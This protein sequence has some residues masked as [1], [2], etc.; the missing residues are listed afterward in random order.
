MTKSSCSNVSLLTSIS[1]TYLSKIYKKKIPEKIMLKFQRKIKA[2]INYQ[3]NN[4]NF[5]YVTIH[6]KFN[7][8]CRCL[9]ACPFDNV[10]K[11]ELQFKFH[12]VRFVIQNDFS[13]VIEHKEF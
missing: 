11:Y 1:V 8:I 5:S 13:P 4:S 3:L 6:V 12:F 9:G 10:K 2:K 7:K